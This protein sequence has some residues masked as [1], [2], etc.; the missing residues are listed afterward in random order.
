M[1]RET[2]SLARTALAAAAA[3]LFLSAPAFAEDDLSARLELTGRGVT[4]KANSLDAFLGHQTFFDLHG[5][6]RVMWEPSFEDFDFT[7]HYKASVQAGQSVDLANK[8]AALSPAPPPPTLFDLKGTLIS[9]P[10]L[11]VTHE[12][13]RLALGYSAPNFVVRGGRQALTWGAGLVFHPLDLVDPFAPNA[14][15]T[16]YKPGVDMLYGQYLFDDGSNLEA[17]AVPRAATYNAVPTWLDSTFA[18]R[19]NAWFEDIG[20]SLSL[21]RDRGD[22]ALGI[23]VSGPLGDA[24]WNAE[25]MPTFLRG[26]GTRISALANISTGFMLGDRNATAFAEYFHNGF[27]VSGSGTPLA[28]LPADLSAR[29]ARGQLFTTSRDYLAAGMTVEVTPLVTASPSVIVNLNDFSVDLAGQVNWSLGDNT[30]LIFG[31]NIPLGN[32]GTEFG[33]RALAAGSAT[34]AAPAKTAYVQLRQYF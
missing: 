18:L 17:I 14:V 30:N 31:A 5:N 29:V 32:D 6:A 28:A 23:G 26:G 12:I 34:Y 33:G 19:Y 13:D 24:T 27:G 21:A 1:R 10:D 20:T 22:T 2:I 11:M 9:T 8:T 15:D 3:A 4:N 16:E 25:L 7:L